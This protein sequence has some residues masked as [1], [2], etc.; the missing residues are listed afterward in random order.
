MKMDITLKNV[1]VFI[2]ITIPVGAVLLGILDMYISYKLDDRF[3]TIE[4]QQSANGAK[5]NML[6]EERLAK[7]EQ[8]ELYKRMNEILRIS[9]SSENNYSL[10]KYK[11]EEYESQKSII[12]TVKPSTK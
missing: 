4:N 6:I 11:M 7:M 12:D 8:T 2:G 10:D 5:L 9:P 1:S 3:D